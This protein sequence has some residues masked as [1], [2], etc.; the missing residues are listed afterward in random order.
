MISA[1]SAFSLSY[2]KS[3]LGS[4]DTSWYLESQ[5]VKTVG[6]IY[7]CMWH[8]GLSE[9]WFKMVFFSTSLVLLLVVITASL[10]GDSGTEQTVSQQIR[11]INK[12]R[13]YLL[14]GQQPSV[15]WLGNSNKLGLGYNPVVGDPVCYTGDCQMAGFGRSL[16]EFKYTNAPIGSCTTKLIPEHVEVSVHRKEYWK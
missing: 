13:N 9:R 10:N 11:L 7:R 8:F 3:S 15:T 1:L 16:F 6:H 12:V 2:Y 5:K 14:F 4:I